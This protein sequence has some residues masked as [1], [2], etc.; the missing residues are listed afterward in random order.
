VV[1][2]AHNPSTGEKEAG[3]SGVQVQPGLHSKTQFKK[4]GKKKKKW[5]KD[6]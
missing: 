5:A 4:K 2:H 6:K 1:V 3:G